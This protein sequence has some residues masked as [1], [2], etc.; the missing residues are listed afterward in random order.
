MKSKNI[1]LMSLS[2]LSIVFLIGLASAATIAEWDF[3]SEDLTADIGTAVLAINTGATES[4]V[5]GNPA[6]GKALS[7]DNWDADESLHITVDLTDYQDIMI[8]LDEEASG[9]GPTDLKVEYSTDGVNYAD[10]AGSTTATL[11]AFA[12]TPMH[13]FDLSAISTI[14]DNA[15]VKIKIT[16]PTGG[17]AAVGTLHV[18]NLKIE[19]SAYVAPVVTAPSMD[20]ECAL[21]GNV[22]TLDI[23]TLDINVEEGFG[24]DE[25]FWYPFDEVEIKFD[26]EN[27]GSWDV[28]NIEI[29]FCLWD[30][31]EEECVLDEGD[32]D[33]SDD[34][35][36]LDWDDD[37]E[38]E[39]IITFT[40]D[41]D[42]LNEGSTDYVIY[43]SATGTIDDKDAPV[44]TQD[45]DSCSAQ[46]KDIDIR[47]DEDF[48]IIKNFEAPETVKPGEE[49]TI[50][51]D[52]WNVGDRDIDEDDIFIRVYSETLR[53]SQEIEMGDLN[54]FDN[55]EVQI[56]L[57]I[58]EDATERFHT[59]EFTIYDDEDMDDNDIYEN[60]END[61]A[62]Y[63]VHVK[64]EGEATASPDALVV[65]PSLVSG[66][67][68]GKEM[69][70]KVTLTNTEDEDR[71]YL[72]SAATYADWA[73]TVDVSESTVI[74]A[75]G[76]SKDVT[77]TFDVK[78]EA[79]GENTFNIEVLSGS[80]LVK[81]QA[82]SVDIEGS[83]FSMG[84]GDNWYLW[85]IGLL[86]V[87]LVVVIIIVAVR[88]ARS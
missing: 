36:D 58:P 3:D 31:D 62:V 2:I 60:S 57:T 83:K 22:G 84:L 20:E 18:D 28:E 82:V 54:A 79:S 45:E 26:V 77:F 17:S 37:D 7:T 51:A 49:I 76:Q 78:K 81:R 53:L 12:A 13:T 29:L 30:Q 27:R 4:Y 47:A 56:T 71:T 63:E 10:L 65:V 24:D 72:V 41:P 42:D 14:E 40:V 61:E 68:A 44:G 9:T 85:L 70:V 15:N 21:T 50:K 34:E 52:V 66:G 35:F 16:S 46:N 32:V 11:A 73:S 8:S 38:Q 80:E 48:V 88:V 1:A 87:I 69:V 43:V 39:V 25:D 74:I 19:G 33:L 64:V 55:E 67:E 75:S 5:I 6:T 86:N 59:F 23:S